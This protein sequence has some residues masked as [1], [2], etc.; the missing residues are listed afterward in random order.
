MASFFY[1][2]VGFVPVFLVSFSL[3]AG[4]DPALAFSENIHQWPAQVRYMS[5]IDGGRLFLENNCFT[6]VLYNTSDLERIHEQSEHC[7]STAELNALQQSSVQLHAYKVSFENASNTVALSAANVLPGYASYFIG[8]DQTKWSSQV[9]S[10]CNVHYTQLYPGIDLDVYSQGIALEYDYTVAANGDASQIRMRYT[11][12][13]NL[14][15]QNGKLIITTSVGNVTEEIPAAYQWINGAKKI[16]SCRYTLNG[17]TVG[18]EF[19]QGYD[20]NYALVIDPVVLAATYSGSTALTYGHCATYDN[21]GNI[22]SAG[23]CFNSGYPVTIGAFQTT[24]S[25][26]V[27]IAISCLNPNATSLIWASYLGGITDEYAHSLLVN[28]DGELYVY[29]S[30][31]SPDYPFTT[32]CYDSTFGSAGFGYDI[33]VS[34]FNSTGTALLGSTFIGGNGNDGNNA[35]APQYGDTYRGEIQLDAAN[36]IYVSSFTQSS[37]FPVT[38]NAYDQTYNSLQDA[39]VFELDATMSN[40]VFSTFLGGSG[41]DAA[42]SMRI[43]SNGDLFVCGATSSTNFPAT[44][45]VYQGA[46]GGGTYDGWVARLSSNGATLIAATYF[47]G[48]LLDAAYLLDL[49]AGNNVY[50]YGEYDGGAP[51][52]P[53]VYSMQ[54]TKTFITKLDIH[55]AGIVFST[56]IGDIASSLVPSAFEV[57]SCENIY[58]AGFGATPSYPVTTNALLSVAMTNQTFYMAMLTPNATA[59]KFASFY[60]GWHVDGGMSRITKEG[61]LYEAVCQGGA[62]FPTPP[63]TWSNGTTAPTWDIV[64]FKVDFEPGASASVVPSSL[65]GCSPTV[66]NFVNNSSGTGFSWDFGDGSPVDTTASPTHTYTTGTYTVTLFVNGTTACGDSASDTAQFVVNIVDCTGFEDLSDQVN[67][68]ISPNPGN[69]LFLLHASG[70]PENELYIDVLDA[71]GRL[72]RSS[73]EKN[74][75][76]D[77]VREI[78]LQALENGLYFVRVRSGDSQKT[79]KLILEK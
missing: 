50:I 39:C 49:D 45:G 22:Y 33:I 40:L 4:N 60:Y 26:N 18:F 7:H 56:T 14:Q 58:F 51:L 30:T 64:C 67:I 70:L 17:I 48:A 43:G 1:K 66:I 72:V 32:G 65:S 20:H 63:G 47:G 34:H 44:A 79:T 55:L 29:G 15:L 46:F 35:I 74:V 21:N 37:D 62:G 75:S 73:S 3:T 2:T 76:A 68:N 59:L 9:H 71:R 12:A 38:A 16:V 10:F 25:G 69:G 52:T 53:G 13:D 42:L 54:G 23:R 27:D 78:D 5:D 8:N 41:D 77:L 28:T 11:G 31:S 24:F 36:N 57:D 6:Y 61:V 19:P